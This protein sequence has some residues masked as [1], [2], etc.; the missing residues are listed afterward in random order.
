MTTAR[1]KYFD[2]L[3]DIPAPG[4]GAGCHAYLLRVAN[5]GALAGFNPHEIA[6]ELYQAV[7]RGKRNV[8]QY[9]VEAAVAK[10]FHHRLIKPGEKIE[11]K[12]KDPPLVSE[13]L[14]HQLIKRGKGATID[15]IM[16]KSPIAIPGQPHLQTRLV[17]ESLYKFSD[18]LYIG[19][20]YS[21]GKMGKTIRSM[22]SWR[23]ANITKDP[24][25]HIVPNPLTGKMGLT[26]MDRPSFRADSCIAQRRFAVVEFDTLSMEDQLAFWS[27]V[28]LPVVVLVTSGGKS[29]HGWIA[30]NCATEDQW[31][32]QIEERLFD[33]IL[34]PMGVDGSCKNEARLSRLPGAIRSDTGNLQQLLYLNPKGRSVT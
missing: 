21:A 24:P 3:R 11:F 5:L 29:I 28:Q 1:D 14:V 23:M 16:E 34:K 8:T 22:A 33:R 25:E 18:L 26:K 30:A 13:D 7:P 2:S 19:D 31:T 15:F 9:E 32:E 20:R 6:R 12:R 27:Q 10:A 4:V 17:L